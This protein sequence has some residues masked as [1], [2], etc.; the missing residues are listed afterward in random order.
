MQFYANCSLQVECSLKWL[1][2]GDVQDPTDLDALF[3]VDLKDYSFLVMTGD[4]SGTPD[5]WKIGRARAFDDKTFVPAGENPREYYRKLLLGSIEKLRNVDSVL[6]KIAKFVKI[7]VVYGNTDLKW[8]VQHAAPKSF[9]VLHKKRLEFDDLF[10]TGYNGHP[11]YTWEIENPEKKDIFDFSYQEMAEE[12]NSFKEQDI[13]ADLGKVSNGIPGNELIV[14]THTPPHGILDRV[15][16]EFVSWAKQS[17]GSLAEDGH[18]GSTG[19]RRFIVER[20]PLVSIFGHIH[21]SKGIERVGGTT[22]VN[23]GAFKGEVVRVQIEQGKVD[24]QFKK[25]S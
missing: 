10:L 21:E 24:V 17:Y 5:G 16:S 19:L 1:A 8:V 14:V 2:I 22:C 7:F 25:V 20:K 4:L 12:L 3:T 11:M 23:T 13:Y 6:G 15:N 9:V 18:V